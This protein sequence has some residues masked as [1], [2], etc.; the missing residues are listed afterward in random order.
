MK[1]QKCDPPEG[2]SDSPRLTIPWCHCPDYEQQDAEHLNLE[3]LTRPS[4]VDRLEEL[5]DSIE[6]ESRNALKKKKKK[7]R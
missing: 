2:K 1:V 3:L 6:G 7:L 4:A 5:R